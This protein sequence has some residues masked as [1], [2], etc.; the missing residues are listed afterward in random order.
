MDELLHGVFAENVG[1]YL[2]TIDDLAATP[3]TTPLAKDL[4]RLSEAWRSLLRQHRPTGPRG[5][6]T[7]CRPRL[8]KRDRRGMC[9]VWKVAT[10]YLSHPPEA[11]DPPEAPKN[12]H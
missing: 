2:D 12:P 4:H 8:S 3:P 10:T 7:G 6:C 5:H 9:E 1:N 11:P